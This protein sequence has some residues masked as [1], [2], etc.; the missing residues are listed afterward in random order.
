MKHP[1]YSKTHNSYYYSDKNKEFYFLPSQFKES[2]QA[3]SKNNSYKN[4][5]YNK[6]YQFWKEKGIFNSS[7]D[8]I[9]TQYSLEYIESNIANLRQLLIEV[10]DACNLSCRYCGYG[11]LYSN[12]DKREGKKQS[13]QNI[14]ALIDFLTEL[15]KSEKN[16][17]FDHIIYI[18][19]YG[20]E[21]LINF[22]LI[23]ETIEYL[24]KIHI[25][26]LIFEYNM[27]TNG[28][29]L[30]K[31]MNYLI[32]KKFHLLISLD[33]SKINN[34][35]RVTSTGMES[36]DIVIKNAKKMQKYA[37]GYFNE[38]VNFNAVLHNRNSVESI[39]SF[40]KKTFNKNPHIGELTTNG[41]NKDLKE[42]FNRMFINRLESLQQAINCEEVRE[43]YGE[44]SSDRM[45]T[46]NFL[47]AFLGNTYK[48]LADLFYDK[49]NQSYMPTSTC[50][51]FYKKLFLTV[52]GRILP[53]EKIGQKISLG[54][55]KEGK[56]SLNS[57][58]IQDLYETLFKKIAKQC[59]QCLLWKN[60]S[61]CIFFFEDNANEQFYCTS[62]LGKN[63]ASSY[64]SSY[65]SYLEKE[66]EMY[67][68]IINHFL[69]EQT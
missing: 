47:D 60:C 26:G 4:S 28:I 12:Y 69:V 10:T 46:S 9:H 3:S 13:F 66:P 36:F 56:V 64:F 40:I 34:S 16:T 18:G 61:S 14:K 8:Q 54:W 6:K 1:F 51:P 43:N 27:T 52:N 23:Q 25:P 49:E 33:G 29:L 5:Y 37:P 20:G 65:I 31:Y 17:S 32:K 11:E 22:N 15:W 35:Y 30:G 67:E 53:C 38:F 57:T 59:K 19:F 21:P 7:N 42:Q 24:E 68:E 2:I 44:I 62:F 55:V 50:P 48:T 58:I 39:Y 45:L 63:K 41:I